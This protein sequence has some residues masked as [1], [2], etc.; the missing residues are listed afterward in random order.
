MQN[1]QVERFNGRF[2]DECL[3]ANW[4]RNMADARQKIGYWHNEYNCDRPYTS[5]GY[6][7]PNEFTAILRSSSITGRKSRQVNNGK[8][9]FVTISATHQQV[10]DQ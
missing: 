7:T 2:R 3:N 10:M 6:R 4:F 5:R 9:R 8:T 1:G